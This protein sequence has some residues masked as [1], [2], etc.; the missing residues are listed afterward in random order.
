MLAGSWQ[1]PTAEI[2]SG[3]VPDVAG[4]YRGRVRCFLAKSR[5]LSDDLQCLCCQECRRNA[6]GQFVPRGT[7]PG[8]LRSLASSALRSALAR[9]FR[10][11]RL[12]LLRCHSLYASDEQEPVVTTALRPEVLRDSCRAHTDAVSVSG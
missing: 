6:I 5:A 8:V 1:S 12:P 2:A 11:T 3:G 4:I 9:S 10:P 7:S